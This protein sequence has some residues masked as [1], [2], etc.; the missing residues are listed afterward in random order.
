MFRKESLTYKRNF[1]RS[2]FSDFC[3]TCIFFGTNFN[4]QVKTEFKSVIICFQVSNRVFG[5]YVV[6]NFKKNVKK[7]LRNFEYS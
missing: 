4:G 7:L 2:V 5:W 3:S 6:L 1:K